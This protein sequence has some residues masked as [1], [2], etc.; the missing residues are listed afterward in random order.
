MIME[1]QFKF[2][3][4]VL[5]AGGGVS[6]MG[7][8]L[9]RVGMKRLS[10]GRVAKMGPCRAEISKMERVLSVDVCHKYFPYCSSNLH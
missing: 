4:E 8:A 10:S 1:K 2:L 9:L 7:R 5:R 6:I 3:G